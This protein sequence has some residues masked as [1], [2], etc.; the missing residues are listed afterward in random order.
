MAGLVVVL[1]RWSGGEA[2]P[3]LRLA[4]A[5]RGLEPADLPP[6]QPDERCRH[7]LDRFC[8]IWEEA[9]SWRGGARPGLRF[10]RTVVFRYRA[11]LVHVLALRVAA[12]L[13]SF[14]GPLAMEKI[15]AWLSNPAV[16]RPWWEPRWVAQTLSARGLYFVAVSLGSLVVRSLLDAREKQLG[17]K[18]GVHCLS[19]V[20]CEVFTKTLA[21]KTHAR[22]SHFVT[23]ECCGRWQLPAWL[24]S[25]PAPT[26]AP[27]PLPPL[28]PPLP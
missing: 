10:L 23:A 27:P 20:Q 15:I 7:I 6:V 14:M 24:P 28:P 9:A 11:T 8:T 2:A 18:M 16:A 4:N 21:Q 25:P 1:G 19:W 12:D 26:A 22:V 3:L 17:L 5:K 13:L